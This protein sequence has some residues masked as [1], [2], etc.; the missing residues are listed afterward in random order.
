MTETGTTTADS[1]TLALGALFIALDEEP[2]Q[3]QRLEQLRKAAAM[4]RGETERTVGRARAGGA[5]WEQ[6]GDALGVSKQ[7]AWERYGCTS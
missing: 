3:V 1:V 5:S 7:A 6:V 2:D 4:V